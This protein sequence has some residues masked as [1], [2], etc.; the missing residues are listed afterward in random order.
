MGIH[1]V[2]LPL[3][4]VEKLIQS[5]KQHP[6]LKYTRDGRIPKVGPSDNIIVS[7]GIVIMRNGTPRKPTL[8]FMFEGNTDPGMCLSVPEKVFRWLQS[9]HNNTGGRKLTASEINRRLIAYID[10]PEQCSEQDKQMATHL[11]P[12]RGAAF[13]ELLKAVASYEGNLPNICYYVSLSER[14]ESSAA[15]DME[16]ENAK[17]VG[18]APPIA[19]GNPNHVVQDTN[20]SKTVKAKADEIRNTVRYS[21]DW[22]RINQHVIGRLCTYMSEQTGYRQHS[23]TLQDREEVLDK[24]TRPA[25]VAR[26]DAA[27]N[28][29]VYDGGPGV[30]KEIGETNVK[31]E[32]LHKGK[33][34]PRSVNDPPYRVSIESG[35]LAMALDPVLKALHCYDHGQHPQGIGDGFNRVYAMAVEA[36]RQSKKDTHP[37]ANANAGTFLQAD[38]SDGRTVAICCND[39]TNADLLHSEDSYMVLET[40]IRHFFHPAHLKEALDIYRSTFNMIMQCGPYQRNSKWTNCSGT[41]ITT[42]LN[43]CVFMVRDILITL[44]AYVFR[45]MEIHG[46]LTPGTY[47]LDRTGNEIG[48]TLPKLTFDTFIKHLDRVGSQ[49]RDLFKNRLDTHIEGDRVFFPRGE[50]KVSE[51]LPQKNG[52]PFHKNDLIRYVWKY[53]GCFFGDDSVRSAYPYIGVLRVK[54]AMQYVGAQDGMLAK[55]DAICVPSKE[56]SVEYLSREFFALHAGSGAS[57]CK[58]EKALAK[59]TVSASRDPWR[60]VSKIL[61]YLTVDWRAPVVG[62]Y[63]QA[64]C[65]MYGLKVVTH[66]DC[67]QEAPYAQDLVV[68]NH[69][70]RLVEHPYGDPARLETGLRE[71]APAVL[72]L[73]SVDRD[74]YYKLLNGSYP[75][76][77]RDTDLAY[78][79]AAKAFGVSSAELKQFDAILRKQSTWN[80][81]KSCALP[82]TLSEFNPCAFWPEQTCNRWLDVVEPLTVG[83]CDYGR[84][85]PDDAPNTTRTYPFS[86]M[87]YGLSPQMIDWDD[88][89]QVD[90]LLAYVASCTGS[91]PPKSNTFPRQLVAMVKPEQVPEQLNS[92][93]GIQTEGEQV[94]STPVSPRHKSNKLFSTEAEA[95][96][97]SNAMRALLDADSNSR[98]SSSQDGKT[99]T[100][101]H[102]ANTTVKPNTKNKNKKQKTS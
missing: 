89:Q 12:V 86:T 22:K 63:L 97:V 98:G 96:E 16:H 92:L 69:E 48:D 70:G 18:A 30:E 55:L 93:F 95:I 21:K 28:G 94:S 50:F 25:Q 7:R 33:N 65:S 64:V 5:S 39:Y 75:W 90:K 37:D 46:E 102:K 71:G 1:T 77:D 99:T 83:N 76:F 79:D 10:H 88:Q 11:L 85:H 72:R 91:T 52:K 35:R 53:V 4:V 47:V 101:D 32:T 87:L 26:E 73:F 54:I 17:A 59:L 81:I 6:F 78:E 19:P 2:N 8:C 57:Y 43:T 27:A 44:V 41:G 40:I 56:D 68:T 62:A 24:R 58:I 67:D 23:V 36:E 31:G 29:P 51:L 15:V 49:Q 74:L 13:I 100:T 45:S 14:D 66:M 84:R 34:A 3:A 9:L 42:I 61:G 82:G 38:G 20:A 80:G 60:Y